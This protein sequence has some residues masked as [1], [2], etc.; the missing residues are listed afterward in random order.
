[1]GKVLNIQIMAGHNLGN[2]HDGYPTDMVSWRNRL[3]FKDAD[4]TVV[5]GD[6][7]VGTKW[8]YANGHCKGIDV[9]CTMN[10]DLCYIGKRDGEELN[11]CWRYSKL[12]G[13]RHYTQKDLLEAVNSVSA[14]KYDS[15]AFF[16]DMDEWEKMD[17][18]KELLSE[19]HRLDNE[20]RK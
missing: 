16:D 4:G 17:G 7:C 11:H 8:K 14:V 18:V 15:V 3:I 13:L 5:Y 20:M 10:F 9:P 6:V 1:M 2:E 12:C 19:Y